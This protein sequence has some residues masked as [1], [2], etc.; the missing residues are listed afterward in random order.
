MP[1]V[2]NLDNMTP[3]EYQCTQRMLNIVLLSGIMLKVIRSLC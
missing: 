3:G 1:N 2:V